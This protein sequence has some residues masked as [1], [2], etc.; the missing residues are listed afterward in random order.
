MSESSSRGDQ[1]LP[2]RRFGAAVAVAGCA[3]LWLLVGWTTGD[4]FAVVW[5]AGGLITCL[6]GLAVAIGRARARRGDTW[7]AALVAA[8]AS[9]LGPL[10]AALLL[11]PP[12]R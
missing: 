9:L 12:V 3:V 2:E 11:I 5:C 4:S 7:Q 1:G 6:A 10:S 8:P